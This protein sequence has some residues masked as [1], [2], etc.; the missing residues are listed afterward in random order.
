MKGKKHYEVHSAFEYS[1]NFA[2]CI[3]FF[4][5]DLLQSLPVVQETQ[6]LSPTYNI[7]ALHQLCFWLFVHI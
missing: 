7:N 4:K 3:K 2:F 5:F 1:R 6:F